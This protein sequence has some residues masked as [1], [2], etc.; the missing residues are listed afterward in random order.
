MNSNM[1]KI[2]LTIAI[3]LGMGLTTFAQEAFTGADGVPE[4]GLFGR[5]SEMFGRGSEEEQP[6]I[7]LEYAQT[8]DQDAPLGSGMALLVGLGAAYLVGKKRNEE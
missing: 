4:R 2:V 5:G 1:K 3:V 8:N 7:D 6:F